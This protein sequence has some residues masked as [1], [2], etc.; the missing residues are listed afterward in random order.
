M[1]SIKEPPAVGDRLCDARHCAPGLN[2]V[3]ARDFPVRHAGA[4]YGGFAG[5]HSVRSFCSPLRLGTGGYLR[6]GR[7]RHSVAR[8]FAHS[9]WEQ[10]CLW[11]RLFYWWPGGF[12]RV[13]ACWSCWCS[14]VEYSGLFTRLAIAIPATAWASSDCRATP[15]ARSGLLH[16]S[17]VVPL[18]IRV[19][20]GARHA[21][22]PECSCL[23][24]QRYVFCAGG[25]T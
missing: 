18:R 7:S 14:L 11:V 21:A 20:G 25:G 9:P 4:V 8:W 12:E 17:S 13:P 2:L 1:A 10:A 5:G 19:F 6:I 3:A 15:W 16:W 24:P 23:F 22:S